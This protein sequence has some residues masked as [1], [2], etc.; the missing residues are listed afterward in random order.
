[1]S[2]ALQDRL[3]LPTVKDVHLVGDQEFSFSSIGNCKNIEN[4]LLSGSFEDA[5]EV[6]STPLQLKS[7]T[8]SHHS[9]L[10][11]VNLHIN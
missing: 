2:A 9:S 6:D 10:D 11:L 5:E 8:L 1:M 3:N 7:L 4:L